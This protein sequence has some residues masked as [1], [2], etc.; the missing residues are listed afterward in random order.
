[1]RPEPD[2][3]TK[4]RRILLICLAIIAIE[5]AILVWLVIR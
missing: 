2:N 3:A 1:M 4:R 5:A